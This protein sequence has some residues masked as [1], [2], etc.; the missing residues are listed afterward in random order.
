MDAEARFNVTLSEPG[1]RGARRPG[2]FS[3]PV[4]SAH[5]GRRYAGRR[6]RRRRPAGLLRPT[7]PDPHHHP[8]RRGDA[9]PRR[10]DDSRPGR[11]GGDQCDAAHRPRPGRRVGHVLPTHPGGL[12]IWR[13]VWLSAR[14]AEHG[15]VG[16][17][18]RRYR[19][20]AALPDV[21]IGLAG[22]DGGLAAPAASAPPRRSRPPGPV[23]RG[24]GLSVWRADEPVVL[25]VCG[26]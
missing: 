23:W 18:D 4:L 22:S 2:S 10:Q 8:G 19:P 15:P 13:G 24:V 9:G 16:A 26:R 12:C 11:P 25:A 5:G 1:P 7:R 14:D 6:A 21:D 3:L 20:L 17:G